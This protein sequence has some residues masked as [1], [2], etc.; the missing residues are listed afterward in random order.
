MKQPIRIRGWISTA[1]L[2]NPRKLFTDEVPRY[3]LAVQPENP[4]VFNELQEQVD[5]KKREAETPYSSTESM[6]MNSLECL[7]K[8]SVIYKYLKWKMPC[9]LCI[10]LNLHS[11]P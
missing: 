6:M 10:S 9:S 7:F 1:N 3:N 11:I 2:I 5:Q 8:S 4:I